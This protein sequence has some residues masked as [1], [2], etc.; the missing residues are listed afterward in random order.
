MENSTETANQKS[1]NWVWTDVGITD[2]AAFFLKVIVA[3]IP[4]S[5]I[6]GGAVFVAGALVNSIGH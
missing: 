4:V 5:I 1:A 6:V 2:L 3:L